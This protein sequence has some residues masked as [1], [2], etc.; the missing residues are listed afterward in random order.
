MKSTKEK[1]IEALAEFLV[2]DQAKM[3]IMLSLGKPEAIA[4]AK[5]RGLTPLDGYPTI[6]EGKRILKEWFK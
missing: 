1:F 5:L 2:K 4:W 6:E 3:S